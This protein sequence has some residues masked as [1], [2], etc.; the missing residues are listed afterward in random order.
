MGSFRPLKDTKVES[1]SDIFKR[2]KDPVTSV[3]VVGDIGSGKTAFCRSMIKYWCSAH[4]ERKHL[5][6]E[7]D[8][9]KVM[10]KYELMFYI[11]LRRYGQI[12]TI[13]EMLINEYR[14][15]IVRTLLEKKSEKVIILL[16]GL[17]GFFAQGRTFNQFQTIGLPVTEFVKDYTIITTSRP[18]KVRKLRVPEN[19]IQVLIRLQRFDYRQEKEMIYRTVSVLNK[20]TDPEQ[21]VIACEQMMDI[22][23]LA[24]LK[25]IP[26]MLLHLICLWFNGKLDRTLRCDFYSGIL[27]LLFIWN[28]SKRIEA[29]SQNVGDSQTLELP[30]H[31]TDKTICALN[32]QFIY[33]MSRLAYKT[34]FNYP[35]DHHGEFAFHVSVFRQELQSS[36]KDNCVKFGILL[37]ARC[38]IILVSESPKFDFSF[39]HRSVQEFLAAVNIAINFKNKLSTSDDLESTDLQCLCNQFVN[40]VFRDRSTVDGILYLSHVIIFLCGLEPRLAY[41]VLKVIYDVVM[42]DPVVK[43]YRRTVD[44]DERFVTNIQEV[45]FNSIEAYS[46][47]QADSHPLFLIG[48]LIVHVRNLDTVCSRLDQQQI[49]PC[50]VRS[51]TVSIDDIFTTNSRN[52]FNYLPMFQHLEKLD[53]QSGLIT[54]QSLT[55][56]MSDDKEMIDVIVNSLVKTVEV[57]VSTLMSLSICGVSFTSMF[58]QVSK[59]VVCCLPRMDNLVALK[60]CQLSLKHNDVCALCEFLKD[61]CQLECLNISVKCECG[62]EHDVDLTK[63]KQLKVINSSNGMSVTNADVTQLEEFT[64]TGLNFSNNMNIYDMIVRA[65]QLTELSLNAEL[66]VSTSFHEN[67]TARLVNLLTFIPNL[68]RLQ[69]TQ[70]RF[71]VNIIQTPSE[72]KHL[73]HI[74][75]RGVAMK[76]ETWR[77]FVDSLN[78]I[79]HSV[80]VETAYLR[81]VDE[82]DRSMNVRFSDVR[83]GRKMD[84]IQYLRDQ[85]SIFIIE[86]GDSAWLSFLTKNNI[87]KGE[88]NRNN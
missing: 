41:H 81:I 51:L 71:H 73:E 48:D 53:I 1:L 79:P 2:E 44:S 33:D 5:E 72:F 13:K 25:R 24:G 58:Y 54:L 23:Y 17:D 37:E 67:I 6:D 82:N 14:E 76:L 11:D 4:S 83:S 31:L 50:S 57:N 84:A 66:S 10:E 28:E 35:K 42:E 12:V 74:S 20:S 68:R 9:I 63:H 16:D 15:D 40:D 18:W 29:I 62:N 77:R 87:E 7:L 80:Y 22:E 55:T 47:C 38:P 86:G 39:I 88:D 21:D 60:I 61:S 8:V 65:H 46:T 3:Y 36:V 43:K 85:D 56:D 49:S 75:F 69:I 19:E 52:F 59:A 64:Y 78:N 27:E 70:F 45:I 32:S 26:M 34:I 30:H